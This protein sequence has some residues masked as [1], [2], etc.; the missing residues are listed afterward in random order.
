MSDR[1]AN[2][3]DME[4]KYHYSPTQSHSSTDIE[5]IDYEWKRQKNGTYTQ[6]DH[7]AHNYNYITQYSISFRLIRLFVIL[8]IFSCLCFLLYFLSAP[9]WF[10][11][12]LAISG[13]FIGIIVFNIR[14]REFYIL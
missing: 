4:E 7:S 2:D 5:G 9:S 12:I 8:F 10:V 6:V 14:S 1:F 3:D 11:F 13:V